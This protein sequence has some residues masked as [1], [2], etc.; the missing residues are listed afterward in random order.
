MGR[1]GSIKTRSTPSSFLA[2]AQSPL[3]TMGS[4]VP[5]PRFGNKKSRNH[6]GDLFYVDPETGEA[7]N[8]MNL[9]DSWGIEGLRAHLPE[10]VKLAHSLGKKLRISFAGFEAGDFA[11][12]TEMIY[13]LKPEHRPDEIELNF[14]CPNAAGHGIISYNFSL[15][16][17]CTKASLSTM[18]RFRVIPTD[19]KVS[20]IMAAPVLVSEKTGLYEEIASLLSPPFQ[21]RRRIRAIVTTNTLP[22][23]RRVDADGHSRI[24]AIVQDGPLRNTLV[25]TGGMSGG[26]RMLLILCQEAENWNKHLHPE[27]GLFVVGGIRRREH[28]RDAVNAG[29]GPRRVL[30]VQVLTAIFVAPHDAGKRILEEVGQGIAMWF[31]DEE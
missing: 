21:G 22:G 1:V 13:S 24:A 5:E 28:V 30:G 20:P 8:A 16:R 17:D 19:I 9:P 10:M 18:P 15:F 27:I 6:R 4:Y 12:F 29:G 2:T 11:R 25:E 3:F 23:Q 26:D 31:P 14:G 7:I